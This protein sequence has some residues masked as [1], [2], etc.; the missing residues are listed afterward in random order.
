LSISFST[1]PWLALIIIGTLGIFT[2]KDVSSEFVKFAGSGGAFPREVGAIIQKYI[3]PDDLPISDSPMIFIGS[4]PPQ[5][6]W[7]ANRFVYTTQGLTYIKDR[8][9]LSNLKDLNPVFLSYEDEAA[10]SQI[11]EFCHDSWQAIPERIM[12]KKV[13]LC[14]NEKL[15]LL[16]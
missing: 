10:S 4:V 3:T 16:L 9:H 13:H 7:Y 15:K 2:N 8:L 6:T 5:P 11:E 12:N 1:L 14:R